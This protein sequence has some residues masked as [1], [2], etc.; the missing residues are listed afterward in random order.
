MW[1][2]F[3]F[4]DLGSKYGH[5]RTTRRDGNCFYRCISYYITGSQEYHSTIRRKLVSHMLANHDV[6]K[7][8]IHQS[9]TL[10]NYINTSKVQYDDTWATEVEIYAMANML[11]TNIFTY[12]L[13]GTS[14]KWLKFSCLVLRTSENT[15]NSCALYLQNTNLNHFDVVT[16]VQSKAITIVN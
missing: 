2:F 8:L 6:M 3:S 13:S 16:D 1:F 4:Q 11:Q 9:T 10:Q 7:T 12:T 14:W 5:V 15:E